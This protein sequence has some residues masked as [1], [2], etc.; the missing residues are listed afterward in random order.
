MARET[1]TQSVP[2][3]QVSEQGAGCATSRS[4]EER[5]GAASK[6][7]MRNG[8]EVPRGKKFARAIGH[9]TGNWTA[10]HPSLQT[11]ERE[12]C[13]F[14]V[15]VSDE[16][17]RGHEAECG[18]NRGT[19]RVAGR[20]CAHGVRTWCSCSRQRGEMERTLP[21]CNPG[22]GKGT[23]CSDRALRG[24]SWLVQAIV[25]D[26]VRKG[27]S[28]ALSLLGMILLCIIRTACVAQLHGWHRCLLQVPHEHAHG[29]G[30][31]SWRAA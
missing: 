15:E 3:C 20:P 5:P 22:N 8:C 10:E 19:I 12:T 9:S 11:I 18:N 28:L 30:C 6:E 23:T 16:G 27:R 14:F 1:A 2:N 13:W 25:R 21:A 17:L 4:Q 7:A 29:T 31:S 26:R 24:G